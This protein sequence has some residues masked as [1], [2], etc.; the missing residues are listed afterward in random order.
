MQQQKPRGAQVAYRYWTKEETDKLLQLVGNMPFEA[1]VREWNRWASKAG[2][3]PRSQQSLRKKA[4]GMGETVR[5]YGAWVRVGEIALLLGKHRSTIHKWIAD[6]LV[7]QHG[8]GHA[9]A[10]PRVDLRRLARHKPQLF[11]G[12]ERTALVQLLEDEALA[13]AVLEQ[14]PKR[15]QSSLNGRRVLWVERGL[16]FPSY[17]AA[18]RAAFICPK[19]I[20]RGVLLDRPVCGWRFRQP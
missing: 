1:V 3:E 20:R 19:A 5:S 4:Q 11:G 17:A 2:I 6:G 12:C 15:H 7:S 13:D 8:A 10:V 14:C 16:V 18:G 9:S